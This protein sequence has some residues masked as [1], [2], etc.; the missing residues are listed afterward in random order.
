MS[1]LIEELKTVLLSDHNQIIMGDLTEE[2]AFKIANDLY[3]LGRKPTDHEVHE[4]IKKHYKGE[5]LSSSNE[6][7]DQSRTNDLQKTILKM[8]QS[9]KK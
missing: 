1:K 2:Q 6:S 8:I 3:Q 4:I 9:Q 7:L 5:V